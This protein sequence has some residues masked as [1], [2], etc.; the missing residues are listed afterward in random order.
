MLPASLVQERLW[1]L[2]HMNPGNPTWSV[3][4]RFRLQGPLD[5]ALLERAFNQIIQRHE[6]LRT[7]FAVLGERAQVIKPAL[8]SRFRSSTFAS[9]R[10]QSGMRKWIVSHSMRRAGALTYR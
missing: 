2:D 8:K 5:P 6:V 3:P 4:V 1:G 7:T 9:S 10:N